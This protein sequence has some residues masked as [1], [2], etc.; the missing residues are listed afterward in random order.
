MALSYP[1][2]CHPCRACLHHLTTG[3]STSTHQALPSNEDQLSNSEAV[4]DNDDDDDDDEDEA[5]AKPVAAWVNSAEMSQTKFVGLTSGI[6][7][8]GVVIAMLI[9]ELETGSLG[10]RSE[11]MTGS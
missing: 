3:W 10:F 9:D 1:L 6:I 2:Q 4:E 11:A 7:V 5:P 8:C